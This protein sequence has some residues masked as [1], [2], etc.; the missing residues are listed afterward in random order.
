MKPIR[1]T[2]ISIALGLTI[3]LTPA[4]AEAGAR[5]AT[6]KVSGPSATLYLV[7]SMHL[8]RR[9]DHPYGNSFN[10]AFLNSQ[11]VYTEIDP[12][13][14][15]SEEVNELALS[16][17]S[18]I[19]L[20]VTK[21]VATEIEY[22]KAS[23]NIQKLGIEPKNLT[24]YKPWYWL[25][26][27]L[28]SSTN[29]NPQLSKYYGMD[30]VIHASASRGGKDTHGLERPEQLFYAM[31]SLSY[32]D[33][34]KLLNQGIAYAIEQRRDQMAIVEEWSSGDA[35]ML[36]HRVTLMRNKY[37]DYYEFFVARRNRLWLPKLISSLQGSQDV[38]VLAGFN[39]IY[40][41]QGLLQMLKNSGYAVERIQ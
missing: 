4:F 17:G 38:M 20:Q 27:I 25:L 31:D 19:N 37:P 35:E 30:A 24:W 28:T 3:V 40:G 1:K 15:D 32:K 34:S 13:E 33:Q 10:Q 39:H 6:W 18:L 7:G 16:L 5:P 41:P 22:S 2:S 9:S 8:L 14:F 29:Q 12:D 36:A 11:A 21:D 26:R 23:D